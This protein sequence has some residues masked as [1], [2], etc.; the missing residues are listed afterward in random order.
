MWNAK[1]RD[2]VSA[3]ISGCVGDRVKRGRT[4][5]P[6]TTVGVGVGAFSR[7]AHPVQYDACG[8]FPLS[9][10]PSPSPSLP[11]CLFRTF[12]CPAIKADVIDAPGWDCTDQQT[13]F[14]RGIW[15][16]FIKCKGGSAAGCVLM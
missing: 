6:V 14:H 15:K 11:L 2:A 16:D 13:G 4:D 9:P 3:W 10:S 7:G 5:G 8:T 12:F 1:A